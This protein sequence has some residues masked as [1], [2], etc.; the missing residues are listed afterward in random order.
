[1]RAKKAWVGL[2]TAVLLAGFAV[3][4][5]FAR[6]E[7]EGGAPAGGEMPLNQKVIKHPYVDS[8]IGT[9]STASTSP[10]GTSKGSTTYR[11]GVGDT[12]L[13]QDYQS[14]GQMA[15][16]GEMKF[17]G[18]GVFKVAD[19]GKTITVW[20]IDTHSPAPIKLSGPLT[21]KGY[22][23]TGDTPQGKLHLTLAKSPEGHR[24]TM[25]MGGMTMTDVYTPAPK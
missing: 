2:A 15:G 11:L 24:F 8:L 20:W 7:D 3:S 18:H 9:W 19:D 16:G 10:M 17:S 5:G 14:V 23:I 12:A 6:A 1:M 25:E 13:L 22:D 4:G 21:D